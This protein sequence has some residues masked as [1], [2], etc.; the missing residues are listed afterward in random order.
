M[1]L[2]RFLELLF[3]F[4]SKN[5]IAML[6]LLISFVS[7]AFYIIDYRHKTRGKIKVEVSKSWDFELEEETLDDGTVTAT[8]K[9]I[10]S[11]K[12]IS[13][14]NV[15]G[16]GTTLKSMKIV[17]KSWIPIKSLAE[18]EVAWRKDFFLTQIDEKGN[19]IQL[20]IWSKVEPGQRVNLLLPY[21]TLL[22]AMLDNNMLNLKN[23]Y[24]G[25]FRLLIEHVFGEAESGVFTMNLSENLRRFILE[26]Q[27]AFGH[28][29]ARNV[30]EN[31]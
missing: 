15:G 17:K 8:V 27:K 10:G 11:Y 29:I 5:W 7:L 22:D 12:P 18:A 23:R 3:D 20:S 31:E 14:E 24:Q 19:L 2:L 1:E 28:I 26:R 25:R 21:V 9:K 6:S 30:P 4:L 16:S 13:L